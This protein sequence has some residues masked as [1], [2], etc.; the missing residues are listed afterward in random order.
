MIDSMSDGRSR[1]RFGRITVIYG[2]RNPGPLIYKDGLAEWAKRDDLSIIVMVDKGMRMFFQ[3][4]V[5]T[6]MTPCPTVWANYR[7]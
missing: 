3:K 6:G 7:R 2:A 5:R 1:S 4:P